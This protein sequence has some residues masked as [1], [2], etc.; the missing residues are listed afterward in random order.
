ME[1]LP[2]KL[3]AGTIANEPLAASRRRQ[4]LARCSCAVMLTFRPLSRRRKYRSAENVGNRGFMYAVRAECHSRDT[5][6]L[7]L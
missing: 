6:Y 7:E 2:K 1:G 4:R 3:G 5:L